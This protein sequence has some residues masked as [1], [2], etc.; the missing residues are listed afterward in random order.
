MKKNIVV[1]I[2]YRLFVQFLCYGTKIE[3]ENIL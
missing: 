1:N 2:S 3:M